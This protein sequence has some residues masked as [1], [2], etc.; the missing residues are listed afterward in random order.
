VLPASPIRGAVRVSGDKSISHRLAMLAALA[1]GESVVRGFLPS[2]DCLGTLRAVEQLGANVARE[3]D[4]VRIRGTG[5]RFRRPAAPLDLGNSGTGARLLAGLLAGHDF[6]AEITGDASLCSRPMRRIQEPLERMGA[7]VELL[8]RNDCAPIRVTGGRLRGIEWRVPVASAQVKSCVLLAGLFA[9]GRTT[10]TEPARSRDHTERLLR[11]LGA[12]ADTAGLTA[13]VTG[14]G[15][16]P[17]AFPAGAWR[18]PGD[19]SSAAFWITAAAC[20]PGS[21][22][23]VADVGLNPRRTALLDVLQRMGADIRSQKSEVR[24]QKTEDSRLKASTLDP[25]PSGSAPPDEWEPRGS[26]TVKGCAL[27]GTEVGGAEIPNLIDELPLVAVAGALAEGRTVLRDAS[28][29]R[30]K[31]SDRI[32]VLAAGLRAFGVRV[33]E[34][35]DGLIVEGARALRGGVQ[36]VSGGDHR[37]AMAFSVLALAADAPVRV[38]DI[39]CVATSYPGFWDDLASLT[40]RGGG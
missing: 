5:G 8:G 2:E 6:A 27:K 32:A 29:L 24:I 25:R 35:P 9:E 11:A 26:V 17:C 40:G 10:V 7:R 22:L 19:F 30:V 23:R 15:G 13:G 20:R 37:M 28:E 34:R 31:E 38:R 3:G 4:T 1:S 16:G 21:E 33:E 14:T 39:S 18:V 36:V 12:P